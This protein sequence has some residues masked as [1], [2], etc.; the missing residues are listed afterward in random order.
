M[1]FGHQR[2][3]DQSAHPFVE[4]A[5]H[6]ARPGNIDGPQQIPIEQAKRLLAALAHG[7]PQVHVEHVQDVAS[8]CGY[9]SAAPRAARVRRW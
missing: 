1:K 6:D 4:I 8:R 9:R 5:Q 7:R 2:S 3:R